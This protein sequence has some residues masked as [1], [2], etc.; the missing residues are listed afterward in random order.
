MTGLRVFFAIMLPNSIHQSLEELITELRDGA[1]IENGIRWL[2][3][4]KSHIT[5]QF[6]ANIQSKHISLLAAK[7][8]AKLKNVSEFYVKFDNLKLFPTQKHPQVISLAIKKQND[9]E[10]IAK[11]IA[12]EIKALNYRVEER[13]L[14]PHI[15]IAH[16]HKCINHANLSQI[17]S[18][19]NSKRPKIP[20][21]KIKTITLVESKPMNGQINCYYPLATFNI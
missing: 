3:V 20:Q 18:I 7:V 17:Q 14:N 2:D 16:L 19:I 1:I 6:L 13:P 5:L 10:K 12:Q 15:T 8:R 11:I 9:L 4:K 21:L